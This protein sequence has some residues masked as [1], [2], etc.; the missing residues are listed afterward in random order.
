VITALD[1]KDGQYRSFFVHATIEFVKSL[2]ETQEENP[3]IT[4]AA[5]VGGCIWVYYKG[6]SLFQAK[7]DQKHLRLII[8]VNSSSETKKLVKWI[9]GHKDSFDEEIEAS[10]PQLRQWRCQGGELKLLSEFWRH[11][12]RETNRVQPPFK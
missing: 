7:P 9:D 4:I 5:Q 6:Q 12:E 2:S 8:S 3:W 10:F 1:P 11:K